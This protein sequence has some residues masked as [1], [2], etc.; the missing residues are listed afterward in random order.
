MT[1][2]IMGAILTQIAGVGISVLMLKS[3]TFGKKIGKLGI[4]MHS[5]DLIRFGFI[6]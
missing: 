6:F 5:L 4:I 3:E 2:A 1:G